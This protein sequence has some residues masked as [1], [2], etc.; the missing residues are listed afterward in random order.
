MGALGLKGNI[1]A[2]GPKGAGT[3]GVVYV[4]WGHDACPSGGA[5]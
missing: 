2:P 5:N 4:R 1:G 3:G